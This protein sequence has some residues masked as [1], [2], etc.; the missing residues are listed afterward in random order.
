VGASHLSID[1]NLSHELTGIVA[2]LALKW[3]GDPSNFPQQIAE[4]IP[5]WQPLNF[6]THNLEDDKD[7][8]TIRVDS[9]VYDPLLGETYAQLGWNGLGQ[10]FSQGN[11]TAILSPEAPLHIYRLLKAGGEQ[12]RDGGE[13]NGFF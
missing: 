5:A 8:W 7:D 11:G 4:G 1:K 10:Q 2:K 6:C 3:R 12:G 9:A 13:R